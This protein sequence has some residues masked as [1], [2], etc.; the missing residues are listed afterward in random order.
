MVP[1]S[2]FFWAAVF[3]ACGLAGVYFKALGTEKQVHVLEAFALI[4]AVL[5]TIM[6]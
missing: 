4:Y 5:P 3:L 6:G 1:E 2:G